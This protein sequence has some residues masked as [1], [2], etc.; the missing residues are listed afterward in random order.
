MKKNPLSPR[1]ASEIIYYLSKR[2]IYDEKIYDTI[3]K[4]VIIVAKNMNVKDCCETLYAFAKY[5]HQHKGLQTATSLI[6]LR[7]VEL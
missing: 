1:F 7:L 4:N 2:N 3:A 5:M 6:T